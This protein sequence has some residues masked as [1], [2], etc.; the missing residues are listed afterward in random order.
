L[1]EPLA[2]FHIVGFGLILSSVWL[3]SGRKPL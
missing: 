3:A 2:L 1:G